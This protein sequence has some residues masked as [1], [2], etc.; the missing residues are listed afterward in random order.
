MSDRPPSLKLEGDRARSGFSSGGCRTLIAS[1][2]H[3]G[4]AEGGTHLE[5]AVHEAGRTVRSALASNARTARLAL[6]MI[7]AIIGCYLLF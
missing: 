3:P 4:S 7:I 6:L 1:E 2:S 5:A